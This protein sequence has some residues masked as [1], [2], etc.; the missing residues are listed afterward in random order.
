MWNKNP[1]LTEKT[2]LPYLRQAS[3]TKSGVTSL[4]PE[5]TCVPKLDSHGAK[6]RGSRCQERSRP[7]LG[8][9]VS[10]PLSIRPQ[11]PDPGRPLWIS[12]KPRWGKAQGTLCSGRAVNLLWVSV[13][14]SPLATSFLGAAPAVC[15]STLSRL[16]LA[17]PMICLWYEG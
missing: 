14:G 2:C 9:G 15:D 3:E 16:A 5:Q 13:Q 11:S 17:G 10:A 1:T 8:P 4:K 7:P 12:S 6:G